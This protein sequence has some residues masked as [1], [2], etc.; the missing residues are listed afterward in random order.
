VRYSSLLT[1]APV[2]IAA[3]LLVSASSGLGAYYASSL[4]A[5]RSLS[6]AMAIG[7]ELAKPLSI[8]AAFEALRSWRLAEGV[9]LASAQPRRRR[10]RIELDGHH[11]Q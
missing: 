1:R 10:L 3:T 11:A 9:G 8:A 6:I 4:G 7:L 5:E 2:A